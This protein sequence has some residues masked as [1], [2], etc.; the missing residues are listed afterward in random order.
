M[1]LILFSFS[2][3]TFYHETF[4]R[5][6]SIRLYYTG[7]IE[8]SFG[9]Q[10]LLRCSLDMS[11]FPFDKQTCDVQVENWAYNGN[12]VSLRNASPTIDVSH[13][14]S[15]AIWSMDST[16]ASHQDLYVSG[17]SHPRPRIDFVMYLSRKSNYYVLNLI[18]P[19]MLIIIVALGVFWLP[20]ESGEKVSLGITVLLA[21]SVFQIVL[22]DSIPATS[23]YTPVLSK[24]HRFK[25]LFSYI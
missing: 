21:F 6:F 17:D 12:E 3:D 23:D 15:N 20:A 8:W 11:Y 19:C 14:A 16:E 24:S 25:G 2:A 10:I 1:C 9:G 22:A 13:Y 7:K 5:D 4:I 18:V